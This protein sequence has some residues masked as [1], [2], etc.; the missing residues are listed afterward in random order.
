MRLE[1]QNK[2]EEMDQKVDELKVAL[3]SKHLQMQIYLKNADK[4]YNVINLHQQC[5]YIII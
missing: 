5:I 3:D 4:H 2:E 1:L